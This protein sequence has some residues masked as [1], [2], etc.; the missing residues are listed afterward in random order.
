MPTDCTTVNNFLSDRICTSC[1]SPVFGSK[2][3]LYSRSLLARFRTSVKKNSNIQCLLK[4][5]GCK[6]LVHGRGPNGDDN[7]PQQTRRY[8]RVGLHNL[9]VRLQKL[10]STRFATQHITLN[11]PTLTASC[12]DNRLPQQRPKTTATNTASIKE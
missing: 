2:N 12:S 1:T 5:Q 6:V 3:H 9:A 8:S 4:S 11:R 7:D 10:H